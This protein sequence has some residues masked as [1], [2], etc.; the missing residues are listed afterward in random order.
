MIHRLKS[1]MDRV[2]NHSERNGTTDR[3][4]IQPSGHLNDIVQSATELVTNVMVKRPGAT[5][6][7]GLLVGA[8]IGF[9]LKRV[10]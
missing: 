8:A 6:V 2:A 10:K 7:V 4:S 1:D 5:L 9:A 3:I